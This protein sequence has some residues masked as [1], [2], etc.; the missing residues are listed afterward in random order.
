MTTYSV[1]FAMSYKSAV[2]STPLIS[3]VEHR[4]V[5]AHRISW[6]C[7][8]IIIHSSLLD[9]TAYI[10]FDEQGFFT[11]HRPDLLPH[12]SELTRSMLW[13]RIGRECG[14]IPKSPQQ[15]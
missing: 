14:T 9:L 8:T 4:L 15:Y 6:I 2:D 11:N 12:I 1:N 7:S 3:D 13:L 5:M 10:Y